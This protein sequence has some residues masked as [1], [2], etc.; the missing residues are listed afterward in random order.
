MCLRPSR[1]Q[2]GYLL[3]GQKLQVFPPLWN[4]TQINGNVRS[5]GEGFGVVK[6]SQFT[7]EKMK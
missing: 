6:V 3:A 5:R 4:S 7:L 2:P 1:K